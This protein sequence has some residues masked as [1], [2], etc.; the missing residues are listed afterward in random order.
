LARFL[1]P[2]YIDMVLAFDTIKPIG[3]PLRKSTGL[4][5]FCRDNSLG[6]VLRA[7]TSLISAP[8]HLRKAYELP[9]ETE[10]H[11]TNDSGGGSR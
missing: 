7:R 9:T 3:K 2:F 4:G 8:E 1:L 10:L 5:N 11:E 6:K